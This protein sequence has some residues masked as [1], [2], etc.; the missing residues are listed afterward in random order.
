MRSTSLMLTTSMLLAAGCV[1]APERPGTA[2]AFPDETEIDFDLACRDRE[3]TFSYRSQASINVHPPYID[4]C[5]GFTITVRI[6]P[7]VDPD[8]NPT[9]IR[10]DPGN[11]ESSEWLNRASDDGATIV[12]VVPETALLGAR[13]KY[14]VDAEGIGSIDPTIRIIR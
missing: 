14:E 1:T 9:V 4:V 13:Y 7:P 12:F 6:V 3:V 11:P 2:G 5:R 8:E 10:S